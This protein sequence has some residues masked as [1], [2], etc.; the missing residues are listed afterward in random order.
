M[1]LHWQPKQTVPMLHLM[2]LYGITNKWLEVA[3]TMV[4]FR[5]VQIQ[6]VTQE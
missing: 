4:K 6:N 1:T 2:E 3:E 5:K